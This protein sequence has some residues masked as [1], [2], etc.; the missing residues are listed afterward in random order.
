MVTPT[1]L[2][3]FFEKALPFD[4]YVK[5]GSI[6]QQTN[7]TN[8]DKRVSLSAAQIE[9]LGSFIREMPVLVIS[10][11]WCGDCAQQVPIFRHF[12]DANKNI[13]LRVIDRDIGCTVDGD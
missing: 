10:G 1:L 3:D 12:A 5:S 2:R 6:D 8:A 11:M 7:W 13:R 9:L 4:Q